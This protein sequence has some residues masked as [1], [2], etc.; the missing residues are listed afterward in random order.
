MPNFDRIKIKNQDISFLESICTVFG[1][2]FFAFPENNKGLSFWGD[3]SDS[4]NN[5]TYG[6]RHVAVVLYD[7]SNFTVF[8]QYTV[9]ASVVRALTNLLSAFTGCNS[10]LTKFRS[11]LIGG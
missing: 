8:H 10:F 4:K 11:Q 3:H 1:G 2:L 5:A 6:G 9:M 7:R